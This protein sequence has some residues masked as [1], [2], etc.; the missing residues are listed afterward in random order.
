[1]ANPAGS[2]SHPSG[3]TSAANHGGSLYGSG[4]LHEGRLLA[5]QLELRV[6]LA[7]LVVEA[8]AVAVQHDAGGHVVRHVVRPLHGPV[9]AEQDRTREDEG[10]DG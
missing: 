6:R 7:S 2:G 8:R 10:H 1:M 3:T 4:P 5:D 9:R